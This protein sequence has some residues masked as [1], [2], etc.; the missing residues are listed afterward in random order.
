MGL[1]FPITHYIVCFILWSCK[2]LFW[3]QSGRYHSNT[4]TG[5]LP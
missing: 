4:H 1:T 5:V 2:K 3:E